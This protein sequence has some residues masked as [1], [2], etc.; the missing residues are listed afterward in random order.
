[1]VVVLAA[2]LLFVAAEPAYAYVDPG[3]GS[4]LTQLLLGG[5]AGVV[6]LL[7]LYWNRLRELVGLRDRN[8]GTDGKA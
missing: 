2:W 4:M 1:M 3:S 8:I 5:G 6:V 7:R